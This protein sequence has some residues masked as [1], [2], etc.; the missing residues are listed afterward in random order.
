MSQFPPAPRPFPLPGLPRAQEKSSGQ[1][2]SRKRTDREEP[3]DKPVP[4]PKASAAPAN[5]P[6]PQLSFESS[7][8]PMPVAPRFSTGQFAPLLP[9]NTF[10]ATGDESLLPQLD[11]AKVVTGPNVAMAL[12][13]LVPLLLLAVLN[14]AP[15]AT[16]FARAAKRAVARRPGSEKLFALG[17]IWLCLA[18]TMP[19]ISQVLAAIVALL[20]LKRR[21]RLRSASKLVSTNGPTI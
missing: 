4:V 6:V 2:V 21:S 3:I 19:V 5:S 17:A 7:P 8:A 9:R 12:L 11:P 13:C 15:A 18:V 14:W 10:F 16:L 20:L 1:E